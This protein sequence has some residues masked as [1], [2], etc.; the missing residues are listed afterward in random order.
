MRLQASQLIIGLPFCL[1]VTIPWGLPATDCNENGVDDAADISAGASADC[2]QNGVPDE[3]D[4]LPGELAL[5]A[6]RWLPS[7]MRPVSVV[8]SDFDGDKL[9]DLASA[10]EWSVSVS[11]YRALGR[12]DFA[13]A[14]DYPLG[15]SH[16]LTES[17]AAGDLDGDGRP[18]I[19]VAESGSVG[20][21]GFLSLLRNRGD[22]T[23][24]PPVAVPAGQSPVALVIA[25][26]D[27]D[28]FDDIAAADGKLNAVTLLRNQE[29]AAVVEAGSLPVGRSPVDVIAADLD[30]DGD[31]DIVTANASGSI[32]VA[33][34]EG[35]LSFAEPLHFASGP[36]THTVVAGDLDRDGDLDL[37][38]GNLGLNLGKGSIAVFRNTGGGFSREIGVSPRGSPGALALVD[39]DGDAYLDL[40]MSSESDRYLHVAWND[41]TGA[42]GEL[43]L[44]GICPEGDGPT[45]DVVA[46]ELDGDSGLDLAVCSHT[47]SPSGYV[48]VVLNRGERFF[49]AELNVSV[50][51]GRAA[52]ADLDGDG[53]T[54]IAITYRPSDVGFP[55]GKVRVFWN[56]GPLEFSLGPELS[57]RDH[58][59][60][61]VVMADLDG[62]SYLDIVTVNF[63]E[64]LPGT[65][66]LSVVLN[67]GAGAFDDARTLAA[68]EDPVSVAAGDLDGD[69]DFDIVTSDHDYGRV[70]VLRNNGA[71]D[72]SQ[73]AFFPTGAWP[74]ALALEDLD[75]DGSLDIATANELHGDV[76]V[77]LNLGSG[78]F[79]TAN[80]FTAGESL[81]GIAAGDL[82]GDGA[83][84]L[85][86][87]SSSG[88]QFVSFLKN[89][90]DGTFL[91]PARLAAGSV[92]F[93]VAA[94]DLDSD[95]DLDLLTANGWEHSISVML[96][97]ANSAF[98]PPIVIAAGFSPVGV[99]AF[100]LDGDRDL[101]VLTEGSDV[102]VV[103][104]VSAVPAAS[105]CNS[106]GIPDACDVAGAGADTN[107]NGIPDE[108]DP[109]QLAGDCNQDGRLNL[110]DVVCYLGALLDGFLLLPHPPAELP[111]GGNLG[112]PGNVL[113]L[114]V[115]GDGV[116]G[117][118]DALFL[119]RYLFADGPAPSPGTS[120]LVAL[121]CAGNPGCR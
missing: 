2:N 103:R 67:R 70:A 75:G 91:A 22:G 82:D 36:A 43:R 59:P 113:V 10:N 66:G 115:D 39:F 84:D 54:D 44:L 111:C 107:G 35:S 72:F 104:N 47:G 119:A 50:E 114:D 3:C 89:R 63:G 90:G 102:C 92:N 58:G 71:A 106:N 101:E 12:G 73:P 46:A 112:D 118:P 38:A 69:R 17:I 23:F 15:V 80:T 11:V 116:A 25:D 7:G 49:A 55:E 76:S 64:G 68:G 57:L 31:R 21:A 1:A 6:A 62:N 60:L 98:A 13:G 83:A 28:G 4:V 95:G 65:G 87:A 37:V 14:A 96:N 120:C 97:R 51:G 33:R 52:A 34:N 45:L 99:V 5:D 93:A 81:K 20:Y 109:H 29:G 85:V 86:A 77:L 30:G 40:A 16:Q 32:T 79:A 88:E 108:C 61:G 74:F 94:T 26:L 53:D 24:A 78:D 27:G 9:T 105:D 41:G 117:I 56:E 42:F 121:E 110:S 19:V 18:E 8:A 48:V 100:D